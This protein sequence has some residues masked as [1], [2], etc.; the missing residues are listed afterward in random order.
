MTKRGRGRDGPRQRVPPAP[1]ARRPFCAFL[2]SAP[3]RGL[4][5]NLPGLLY[6]CGEPSLPQ[7]LADKVSKEDSH[8]IL[9]HTPPRFPVIKRLRP[10]PLW[11]RPAAGAATLPRAPF[12]LRSPRPRPVDAGRDPVG[13]P[14]PGA[15]RRP[16]LSS[17]RL[18]GRAGL[19]PEPH[20][21]E[22]R[23]GGLLSRPRQ[24]A[25]PRAKTPTTCASPP[26]VLWPRPA[27][28]AP[29]RATSALCRPDP[30]PR[31][32]IGSRACARSG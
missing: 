28:A 19:G 6:S 21:R 20:A 17:G 26:T 23:H 2:A 5:G 4:P 9:Y 16:L 30:R 31:M 14:P 10:F 12:R 15:Q 1:P 29:G 25:Y 24:S 13:L 27:P 7:G 11:R 8:V 32:A 22:L 3:P 18:P